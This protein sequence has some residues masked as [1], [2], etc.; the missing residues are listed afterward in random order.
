[1]ER[2]WYYTDGKHERLGESP[3]P[4]RLCSTQIAHGLILKSNPGLFEALEQTENKFLYKEFQLYRT[5]NT[6]LGYTNQSV[7][8]VQG[9]NRCS[10][11]DPHKTHKYIVRAE[12][13]IVEC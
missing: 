7:N 9:N 1:M 5:V 10:F 4:V 6:L 13:R 3:L 12:S 11:A 2:W 8:A